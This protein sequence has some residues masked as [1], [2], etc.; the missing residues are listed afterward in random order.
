MTTTT[1]PKRLELSTHWSVSA[2]E[3]AIGV[4]AE[5]GEAVGF[6]MVDLFTLEVDS[7]DAA[8]DC[9]DY[10]LREAETL[11]DTMPITSTDLLQ[12]A[13]QVRRLGRA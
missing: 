2:V 3:F 11:S 9:A 12:D 5:N 13:R 10:I 6:R 7:A 1:W 4:N 8:G